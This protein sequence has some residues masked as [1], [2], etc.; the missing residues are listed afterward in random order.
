[1]KDF[2]FETQVIFVDSPEDIHIKGQEILVW[3]GCDWSIDYVECCVDSGVDY[4][5]NGTEVVAYAEL[6]KIRGE[7]CD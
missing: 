3:D 5:A 7:Q 2:K 1:M 4:M 6:P